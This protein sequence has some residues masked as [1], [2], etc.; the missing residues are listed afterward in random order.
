MDKTMSTMMM[1]LLFTHAAQALRHPEKFDQA[2]RES[3]AVILDDLTSQTKGL[4][5]GELME[6][7]VRDTNR[8]GA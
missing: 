1:T 2:A 7:A 8:E 5:T 3:M 4:L 6:D